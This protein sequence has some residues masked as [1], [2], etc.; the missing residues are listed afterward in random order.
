M[1]LTTLTVGRPANQSLSLSERAQ[2]SCKLAKDL[3]NAGEYEAACEALIEFW[4]AR[5]VQPEL[6]GLDTDSRAEVLLRVGTLTGWTGSASQAA[7]AQATAKDLISQSIAVFE[8]LGESNRVIEA[9]SELGVCYWREGAFDEARILFSDVIHNLGESANEEK[10]LAL[11]RAAIVE[12]TAGRHSESLSIYRQ[13]KALV[14]ASSSHSLKGRFHNGLG[15]LLNCM[16]LAES[17]EDKLDQALMEFTAASVH[18]EQ[19]GHHRYR[20]RVEN[21]L[22]YLFCTI[23]KFEE[24][25]TH[26]NRAR[27]LF[28]D[29][30]DIGGTAGVDETR[31]RALLAEGRL[32]E[33]ERFAH[34]AVKTLD[35]GGEQ[36]LLAEALTT[37]GTVL[38]RMGKTARAKASL[39]RAIEVAQTSGDLEGA[40]R[41]HLNTIEELGQQ[42]SFDELASN[43]KRALDLL[44]SSQDPATTR[45]LISC[46]QKV[47][48]TLA[49]SGDRDADAS[50]NGKS[51]DGFSFKQEVLDYEKAII[52]RALR[53][54]GGAVTKAARLLG[55]NHHQSLIA[56]INSRHKGLLGV[57]SAV[58]K[59]RRSII[60][61]GKNRS[62]KRASWASQP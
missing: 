49:V 15:T 26:L 1:N 23:G 30:K 11:V 59:R 56:L 44:Q 32:T 52:S 13:G 12:M 55:F 45:R 37:H 53:D 62:K 34:T 47:I 17:S 3:E 60:K 2:Y 28:L 25:H 57:R 42:I 24:A 50:A 51:W 16:A 5:N 41:A 7:D 61:I 6:K 4:P 36:S 33:A 35:L 14:E 58:R 22:G 40:G 27:R 18:F 48:G 21:N 31:A 43:Y 10:A 54:T 19:A 29:L 39:Q 9:R 8:E 46:A 20:A 38:A